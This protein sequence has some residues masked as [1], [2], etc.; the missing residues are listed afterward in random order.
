MITIRQDGYA[1]VH[2]NQIPLPC[3][4]CGGA[5]ELSQ[6]EHAITGKG[7]VCIVSSS[8]IQHADTFWFQC[9]SCRA[10]SG[11]HHDSAQAAVEAW[12]RRQVQ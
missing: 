2:I 7:R 10:S 1:D 6:L 12:N 3:P 8:R 5:A 11:G 4:F 9:E